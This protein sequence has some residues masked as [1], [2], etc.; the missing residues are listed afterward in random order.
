MR[1]DVRRF[2]LNGDRMPIL[3]A[4]VKVIFTFHGL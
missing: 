1:R 2:L 3:E 4:V